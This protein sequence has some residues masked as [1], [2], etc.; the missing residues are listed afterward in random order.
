M[1]R[2]PLLTVPRG[3]QT[4]PDYFDGFA[5]WGGV[6]VI[7]RRGW[8]Q[9]TSALLEGVTAQGVVGLRGWAESA[10]LRLLEV[11]CDLHPMAQ[12]AM[13]NDLS[14]SFAPGSTRIVAVKDYKAGKGSVDDG[15]T[16]E[17]SRLWEASG[18]L[19]ALQQ[20]LGAHL[21][22]FG[23]VG[24]EAVP[25]T[26]ANGNA[27]AVEKAVEIE[28][29]SVRYK[30][31]DGG[32][33]ALQQRQPNRKENGG[34]RTLDLATIFTRAWMGSRKN[35]YGRPRYGAFL[36]EGLADIAEQRN[37]RD[38][39]HAAAWPRL[40]VHFPFTFLA[41]WAVDHPEVLVVS[42]GSGGT[43][44]IGPDEWARQQFDAMM[45]DFESLN[46]SDT[47]MVPE[48]TNPT[49]LSAGGVSGLAEVL[50]LR[51]LRLCEA[52]DQLPALLG[53]TDGG[54]QAYATVQWGVQTDKLVSF[55]DA[56]NGVLVSVANLHL[57]L[58]GLDMIARADTEPL[59][60]L[61]ALRDAQARAQDIKNEFALGRAGI[62]SAEEVSINL[63]GTGLHDETLFYGNA[64]D[65][66]PEPT[67]TEDDEDE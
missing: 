53:I 66:D 23:W 30:G 21:N 22:T 25:V 27:V 35:P 46:S 59:R 16:A 58:M 67:P 10:P 40:A 56:V 45:A 19:T 24:A 6:G 39:L 5:G 29:L 12:M 42:D 17:I 54:T 7:P 43:K 3:Q 44:T 14:L 11:L 1:R 52:L 15:A 47:L 60:S 55:R 62:L 8:D 50:K 65:P 18:G 51:R 31:Q 28:P 33:V 2:N 48:G 34:W 26:D 36:G 38:W 61:D 9:R 37:L 57:R 63:T 13:S 49:M 4:A 20:T 64:T 32:R 41:Q